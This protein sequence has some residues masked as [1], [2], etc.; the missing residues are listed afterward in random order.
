LQIQDLRVAYDRDIEILRGVNINVIP[1]Q[2]TVI[3][4]PNGAGKS[5]LL[6]AIF[7]LA[8]VVGGRVTLD[9][10]DITG[11]PARELL[12][13]RMVLVP[14][15]RSIF[16][17]M[18]VAEN[19]RLG[20]WV[21]RRDRRWLRG[22]IEQVCAG[23]PVLQERIEALAGNLSGGQQKLLEIMRGLMIDPNILVLD[24]PTAG[25]APKMAKQLYED[26]AEINQR[27]RVTVLL[28]DQN[29]RE[30]LA[31]GDYIYVLEMG[32]NK[33]QGDRS[34]VF[35]RLDEIVRGWM[36]LSSSGMSDEHLAT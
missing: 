20:G 8:P 16:P 9:H 25:L 29:V 5:T 28:V 19:L 14:Q 17:E 4:G 22:R 26:I 35:N 34:A 36:G 6:R 33:A 32:R 23:F 1:G 3:I 13:R 27:L 7:G 18:T 15:E 31:L 2:V 24:E 10:A 11:L 12:L 21:R 30:A